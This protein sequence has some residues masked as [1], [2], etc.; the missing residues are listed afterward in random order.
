LKT[1]AILGVVDVVDC[2]EIGPGGCLGERGIGVGGTGSVGLG[3]GECAAIREADPVSRVADV[4]WGA[5]RSDA[6]VEVTETR[7]S[8]RRVCAGRWT[9]PWWFW[10]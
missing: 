10:S 6:S 3:A 9:N 5:W 2:V 1:G 8:S 4:V 7:K